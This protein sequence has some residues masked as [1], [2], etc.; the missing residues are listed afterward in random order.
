[1]DQFA[2]SCPTALLHLKTVRYRNHSVILSTDSS[3]TDKKIGPK[4]RINIIII[5]MASKSAHFDDALIRDLVGCQRTNSVIHRFRRGDQLVSLSANVRG[6]LVPAQ[7][8]AGARH[9][10]VGGAGGIDGDDAYC[11]SR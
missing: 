7:T 4:R 1:M 2:C 11:R 8:V 5:I 6:R 3:D 10:V 9:I